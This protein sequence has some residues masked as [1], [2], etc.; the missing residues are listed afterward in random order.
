RGVRRADAARLRSTARLP[1]RRRFQPGSR[2]AADH[3]E[4]C[5]EPGAAAAA[6]AAAQSRWMSERVTKGLAAWTLTALRPY[7]ARM[8]LLA[9]LLALEIGLGALQPWPF[10][11]VINLLSGQPMPD[12]VAPFISRVPAGYTF[13]LLVVVVI[14]GVVLQVVNQ[15]VS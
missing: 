10:A 4:D 13:E 9:V 5:A 11:I 14:A 2:R 3:P 6:A 8:V 12:L 15:F 1:L 7:R